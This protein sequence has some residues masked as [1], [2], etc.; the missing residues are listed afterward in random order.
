[1][2]QP[3]IVKGQYAGTEQV[4]SLAVHGEIVGDHLAVTP[5]LGAIGYGGY[6]TVTH[7]PTG[8]RVSPRG[9]CIA[10]VR[11]LAARLA[12]LD[13]DWSRAEGWEELPAG[14]T[15]AICEITADAW[16]GCAARP[17]DPVPGND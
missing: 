15:Q 16:Q 3:V 12:N 9:L 17:C 11:E 4:V 1:M 6:W 2:L 14:E 5:E 7:I 10:C 13:V 8:M